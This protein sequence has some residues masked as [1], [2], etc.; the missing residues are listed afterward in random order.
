MIKRV[1]SGERI[2]KKAFIKE[3]AELMG[4]S[5]EIAKK[6]YDAY[7]D[8][9]FQHIALEDTVYLPYAKIGGFTKE[10]MKIGGFYSVLKPLQDVTRKGYTT[11]KS[12]YPFIEW[13]EEAKYSTITHPGI[14]YTEWVPQKYTTK[15]YNFR[16]E[17]GYKEIPEFEGLKEDKIL[18]ICKNAD[19]QLY[20]K[21]NKHDRLSKAR[22]EK[23]EKAAKKAREEQL[24]KEVQEWLE[25]NNIKKV[26]RTLQEKEEIIKEKW[27]TIQNAET[28]IKKRKQDY[29]I[30][31]YIYRK[32][33]DIEK[34]EKYDQN[35]SLTE[36][37]M[38]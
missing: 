2:T 16:K 17:L 7:N 36:K 21:L 8:L 22:K 34:Q 11:A 30:P 31:E 28:G 32:L 3:M 12:G 15:A 14:Y 23:K 25:I 6:A 19:E 27:K 9:I 37:E 24:T 13:T 5:E 26:P 10:P 38:L 29:E 18:E 20:G 35:D 4:E 33:K 1:Q